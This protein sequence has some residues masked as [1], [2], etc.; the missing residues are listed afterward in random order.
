LQPVAA[1]AELRILRALRRDRVGR[2]GGPGNVRARGDAR[3]PGIL[4]L[5]QDRPTCYLKD[6]MVI[7]HSHGFAFI[8]V[9]KTGGCS[10]AVA[11]GPW[12]DD[13]LRY[14]PNRWLDRI[15]VH[16]NYH[17]PWRHKR[18]RTHTPAA[19]F[20]RHLPANVF[21]GLFTFA[22]V[23]NP[24]DLLVSSYHFLRRHPEHRRARHTACFEG[25]VDYE[26]GRGKLRQLPMVADHTGRLLVDFVGRFETLD[27]DFLAVC[28][29]IGVAAALPHL[30]R[31]EHGDYRRLYSDRLAER[32]AEHFVADIAHFGYTFDDG[33]A[34]PRVTSDPHH[35]SLH[36][37]HA[38][39]PLA[40]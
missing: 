16:V 12:A 26:I 32:V 40:S 3:E 6:A 21:A 15:G 20:A 33:G 23:R 22:F 39:V 8:H 7:S 11:L 29:R 28:R 10:V 1:A 17:A 31:T 19:L 14:P 9:P 24:W 5:P 35:D 30:N 38:G 34:S 37:L 36:L 4:P 27:R 18:F 25:Y 13:P 2:L